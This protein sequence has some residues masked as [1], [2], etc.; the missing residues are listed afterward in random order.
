M[1]GMALGGGDVARLMVA[2]PWWRH[3]CFRGSVY[4]IFVTE[5][6]EWIWMKLLE[7]NFS[8]VFVCVIRSRILS[9]IQGLNTELN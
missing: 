1:K 3:V 2:E 4:F 8:R 5:L 9:R 6:T 7:V